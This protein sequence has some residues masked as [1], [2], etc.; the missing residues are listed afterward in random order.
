MD[1]DLLP[2]ALV[3]FRNPLFGVRPLSITACKNF[4][5]MTYSKNGKSNINSC[6][7]WVPKEFV[8]HFGVMN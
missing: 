4:E 2:S 7:K 3:A 6:S 1:V 5:T 8:F